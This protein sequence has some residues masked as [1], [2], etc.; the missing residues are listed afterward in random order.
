MNHRERFLKALELEEPDYVPITDLA[1]DPPIVEQILGRP[2]GGGLYS[3]AGGSISW[4]Q[5]IEYRLSIVEACKKLDF[6]AAVVFSN[7]SAITKDYQP[8]YIDK[9]RYV[10]IW[11]R[12]LQVVPETK[13]TFFVGGTVQT[14]EDLESYEPPDA[15]H[16]DIYEMMERVMKKA[17]KEDLAILAQSHSGWHIAFQV[18]GGID[19][20]L[21]DFYFNPSF[22]KK[23]LEKVAKACQSFIKAEAELGADAIF[24]TDD[25]AGKNGPFMSPQ[26]FREYELPYLKEA[27]G[28]ARKYG[29]PVLKHSDGNI[30]P[31]LDD[32]VNAGIAALHP[33]QPGLMDLRDVKERYGDRICL[34]G[35]VDCEYVLPYGSEEDVRRDV[36]RCIDAAAEGGGFILSSSNSLHANVKV[37]NIYIMVD[38]A[39]KYGKYPLTKK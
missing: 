35:N 10:D 12:I 19:K 2:L 36:R 28:I 22:A 16:P 23:L 25:Y 38:E 14:L 26:Q 18:R 7:Y 17:K 30:Y 4:E 37:E 8:K 3:V 24:I 21:L 6:D 11:G 33:I 1:L 27:I 29:V 9:K 31:I 5:T 13:T 34:I 15:F 20:L 32:L 39:R